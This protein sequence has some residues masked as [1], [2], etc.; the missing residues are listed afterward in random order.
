MPYQ[1]RA[2]TGHGRQRRSTADHRQRG[3]TTSEAPPDRSD[4]DHRREG[5]DSS[6][7]LHQQDRLDRSRRSAAADRRL[8]TDGVPGAGAVRRKPGSV[9]NGCGG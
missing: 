8:R 3:R 5:A 4:A 1:P 6:H 9:S 7:H 2:P